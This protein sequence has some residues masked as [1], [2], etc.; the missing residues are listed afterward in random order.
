[1]F[2]HHP[3]LHVESLR[4]ELR[5]IELQRPRYDRPDYGRSGRLRTF[6][7]TRAQPPAR[8]S[9]KP[10]TT[11]PNVTIRPA[12]AADIH[13]LTR[14]AEISERRVPSGLVLV[15]EVESSIVAA[16]AVQGGPVLSDLMRP[17]GDVVQLLE[18][19]SEQVRAATGSSRAA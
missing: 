5:E 4:R 12:Q 11:I 1:M 10:G 6:L 3:H 9:F 16:R 17:T 7:R 18:L 13:N 15:A 14:L 8:A 2:E 19:R